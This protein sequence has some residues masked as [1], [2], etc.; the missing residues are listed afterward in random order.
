M[1]INF[2]PGKSIAKK[3]AALPAAFFYGV[4]HVSKHRYLSALLL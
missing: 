2:Y 1:E 3:K 4:L